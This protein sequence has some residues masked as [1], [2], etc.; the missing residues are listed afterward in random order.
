MGAHSFV[1]HVLPRDELG[2]QE[3][4]K[5]GGKR[6]KCVSQFPELWHSRLLV[7]R[8]R[9]NKSQ[10]WR[11]NSQLLNLPNFLLKALTWKCLLYLLA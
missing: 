6:I 9:N 5:N 10:R 4:E 8:D 11:E 2:A 3:T 7:Y 1:A